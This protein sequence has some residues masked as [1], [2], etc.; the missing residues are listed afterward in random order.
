MAKTFA[1]SQLD[2][3]DNATDISTR[4]TNWLNALNIGTTHEVYTLSIEHL[5]GFWVCLVVYEP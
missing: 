3:P 1:T 5:H 4:I 2:I